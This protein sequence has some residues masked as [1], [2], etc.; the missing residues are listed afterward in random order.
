MQG[1][2]S[3]RSIAERIFQNEAD[4]AF[5]RRA[6][7]IGSN[8]W[9]RF[10]GQPYSLL[11][12]GCGRGFYFPLY[13]SLGAQIVGVER[14]AEPLST[15]RL[16]A[17]RFGAVVQDVSADHLP[18]PDESFDAVVMSE[19]LEHLPMPIAALKEARR[20][21]R[22]EGLLLIT[23]PNANYPFLWDPINWLLERT[24]GTPIRTGLLSG[25]WANHERLYDHE[26]LLGEV[27]AAGFDIGQV[28]NHTH[29]CMPFVHNIVYGLGKPL[30][31]K[32]LLPQNWAQS[33]ERGTGDSSAL[34]RFNPVSAGIRLIHWFDRKNK[35]AESET[36][37][38]LNICVMATPVQLIAE[39]Q[40]ELSG[41]PPAIS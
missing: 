40:S 13:H 8:L 31:E 16:Q 15:A 4:P 10:L 34:H 21:L 24:L 5:R 27:E 36:I 12:I 14:D 33:A 23:V 2:N 20:V 3:G 11:D 39:P 35:D 32:R 29:Y 9:D 30:L 17:E 7:W 1:M 25:I 19:L 37:S 6:I 18:F 41:I 38:T 28:V 26:L 22:P